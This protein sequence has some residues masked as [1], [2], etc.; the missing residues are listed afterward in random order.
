MEKHYRILVFILLEGS[1]A[2][3]RKMKIPT[4]GGLMASSIFVQFERQVDSYCG[5]TMIVAAVSLFRYFFAK[6]ETVSL[7]M[8]S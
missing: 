7:V 3:R 2:S 1:E 8:E 4:P 5:L 6:S